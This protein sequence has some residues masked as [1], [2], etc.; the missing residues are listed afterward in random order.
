MAD[1]VK[2][3]ADGHDDALSR[4]QRRFLRRIFNGRTV[5]LVVDGTA[6][7]TYREARQ[8]L[9]SVPPEARAVLYAALRAQ[10]AA[11]APGAGNAGSEGSEEA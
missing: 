8:Q 1:P 5:P 6:F 10:A 11:G 4:P 9:L 7:L 3:P 2:E